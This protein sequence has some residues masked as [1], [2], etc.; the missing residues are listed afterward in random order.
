MKIEIKDI[1]ETVITAA[2]PGVLSRYP[3][4]MTVK[5]SDME[6]HQFIVLNAILCSFIEKEIKHDDDRLTKFV[7]IIGEYV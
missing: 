5:Y 7:D 1:K 2:N 3:S 4:G 6:E